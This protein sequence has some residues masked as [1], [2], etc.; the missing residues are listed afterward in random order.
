MS[1]LSISSVCTL[2]L[3]SYGRKR[4]KTWCFYQYCRHMAI[5]KHDWF[6]P[7]VDKTKF[8]SKI[9][10]FAVFINELQLK[11]VNMSSIK[12]DFMVI[13]PNLQNKSQIGW[14]RIYWINFD[15][16][17]LELDLRQN[18]AAEPALIY[19]INNQIHKV[20]K[21]RFVSD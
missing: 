18:I 16:I 1:I 8:V 19:W 14:S 11:M 5:G 15:W 9:F 12:I 7:Q 21:N 10:T 6:L 3:K 4:F 20:K 13:S 17:Y 2:V